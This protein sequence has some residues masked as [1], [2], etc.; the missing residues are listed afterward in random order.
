MEDLFLTYV[1]VITLPYKDFF[2][3]IAKRSFKALF[4]GLSGARPYVIT[5]LHTND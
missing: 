1:S 3:E 5:P 4:I 2:N